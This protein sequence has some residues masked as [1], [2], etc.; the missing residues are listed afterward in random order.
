MDRVYADEKDPPK[1]AKAPPPP[2][3]ALLDLQR[4]AGNAAV[5]QMIARDALALTGAPA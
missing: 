4:S 5:S 2:A 3:P 1:P